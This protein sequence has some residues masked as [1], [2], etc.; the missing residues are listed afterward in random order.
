MPWFPF[1]W[2]VLSSGMCHQVLST[3]NGSKLLGLKVRGEC[4]FLLSLGQGWAPGLICLSNYSVL[5]KLTYFSLLNADLCISYCLHTDF[6]R[7]KCF[8]LNDPFLSRASMANIYRQHL[9]FS[10]RKLFTA[11]LISAL[12]WVVGVSRQLH[13]FVED[14]PPRSPEISS[15]FPGSRRL[16]CL[17]EKSRI[18]GKGKVTVRMDIR[19]LVIPPSHFTDERLMGKEVKWLADTC[20]K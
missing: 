2:F 8:S 3:C 9:G 11:V 10:A 16:V 19:S 1:M 15:Y 5:E 20:K 12:L 4:F 13:H 6:L 17:D 14:G 7:H 18:W